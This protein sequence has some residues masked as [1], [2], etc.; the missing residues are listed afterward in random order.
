MICSTIWPVLQIQWQY[1]S[2]Y[3]PRSPSPPPPPR[4]KSC[5]T[6]AQ[7]HRAQGGSVTYKYMWF[8]YIIRFAD[9]GKPPWGWKCW[10]PRQRCW[11]ETEGP[12]GVSGKE[13]TSRHCGGAFD[14]LNK[15]VRNLDPRKSREVQTKTLIGGSTNHGNYENHNCHEDPDNCVNHQ[16]WENHDLSASS[17]WSSC[18]WGP[19][20]PSR[21]GRSSP[22][23]S[24]ASGSASGWELLCGNLGQKI[25]KNATL[26]IVIKQTENCYK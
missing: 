12:A 14:H 5:L 21:R 25:E 26:I 23:T 8:H 7:C 19:C 24:W 16:S 15:T 4:I 22:W 9:G 13:L 2:S 18:S 6:S 3:Q 10:A 1:S 20:W 17:L 11:E